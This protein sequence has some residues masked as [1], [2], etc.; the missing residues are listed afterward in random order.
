MLAAG[1]A[2]QPK[3]AQPPPLLHVATT[4][5]H[6]QTIKPS[7][8]L[9]G[10]V[11]PY[12]N[13]AIQS[14]LSEP[15]DSVTVQEGDR[16]A[17]GQ[18][19]ARLDVADLQAQ[20]D[21]DLATAASDRANTSHTVFSGSLS[22][23]QGVAALRS[24]QTAVASA[25]A[26]LQNDRANLAR[27]RQLAGQGYIAQQAVDA[28]TTLVLNDQQ[29]LRAAQATLAAALSNVKANGTLDRSGLQAST[30]EQAK[31]QEKVALAQAEQTRVQIQKATIASPIDGI[32]VNRNLNPGEYPGTR[33]VFTIQQ[34]DPIYAVLRGSGAQIASIGQGA[35]VRIIASDVGAGVLTGTVVGV[36]NQI[37]P[38][39]TDF[40]VKVLLRN[41]AGRL[42]PGM[43]VEGA[44]DLPTIRGVGVPATAF[45]D[46]TRSAI[47][48]VSS[49][50]TVHT[51]HV[52]ETGSDDANSIVTGL[53]AGT[54][55]ITNGQ[56]G[57]GDGQKV[58]VR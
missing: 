52:R 19:L 57:V 17:R 14:T 37:A 35:R 4:L 48:T 32:V 31:A 54:R 38:G 10:I 51:V 23:D 11:A 43:A 34:I 22:I 26:T 8:R 20:L 15:A 47:L 28:Q 42:R 50:D 46:D 24:A 27:D 21:A 45:T 2:G 3:A 6:V 40:Q 1:C 16:V 33:Q 39:S 49:D 55:V 36:L 13:V 12:Q 58:A 18:I 56:L 7:E 5:V 41:P 53:A 30:V 29:A 25:Q 9:A 44:V